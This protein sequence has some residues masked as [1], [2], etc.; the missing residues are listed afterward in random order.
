LGRLLEGKQESVRFFE[1]RT[2]AILEDHQ[3]LKEKAY[4]RKSL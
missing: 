2:K 3:K 1:K 4:S